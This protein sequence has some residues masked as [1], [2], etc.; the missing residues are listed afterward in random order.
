[1]S[2]IT[3]ERVQELEADLE[4][5]KAWADMRTEEVARL[6]ARLVLLGESPA[7][8]ARAKATPRIRDLIDAC[9]AENAG[10]D[11]HGEEAFAALRA[12]LD[13]HQPPPAPSDGSWCVRCSSGEN[14]ETWPCPT[15]SA[16]VTALEAR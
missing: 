11:D 8:I 2:Q 1:M 6:E 10:N 7:A 15:L 14:V 4:Q 12:V 5:A 16:I 13:L 3:F 9:E